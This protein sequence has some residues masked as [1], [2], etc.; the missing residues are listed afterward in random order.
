MEKPST[1]DLIVSMYNMLAYVSCLERE[2]EKLKVQLRKAKPVNYVPVS[3]VSHQQF[4]MGYG[5]KSGKRKPKRFL[6]DSNQ[7]HI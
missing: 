1:Y 3:S 4:W 2:N 5:N 6:N 7:S